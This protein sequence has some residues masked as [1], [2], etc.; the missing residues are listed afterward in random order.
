MTYKKFLHFAVLLL[1]VSIPQ[2]ASANSYN[3]FDVTDGL[4][5]KDDI[6]SGGPQ[7]DGIPALTLPQFHPAA[8]DRFLK[9]NDRILGIV[10]GSTAKA[11][12]LKILNWHE[13]INDQI[14][15]IQFV[16]TYCPLCGTGVAFSSVVNDK[17]LEFGVSGLLY[18]SDVL[19]YDRQTESLWSQILGQAVTGPL[20]GT[21]LELIPV[22]HTSWKRWKETSPKTLVLS[23]K[24]GFHRDYSH[25]PYAGYTNSSDLYFPVTAKSQ[26]NLHPKETV[27][28]ITIGNKHKA[29]P[30]S[31]LA[32]SAQSQISD[33][34]NGEFFTIH[35]D[36][37]GYSAQAYNLA[38]N[39]IQSIQG[40]WF[41]WY[42]FHPD[43]ELYTP[44]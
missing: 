42:A 39:P 9:E 4:I 11:Y 7:K 26:E 15:N 31:T 16:V 34:L 21:E 33:S 36:Q 37:E 27:L 28:G 29:Y 24:T 19:L 32:E 3:G 20:R 41:A 2:Q 14:D 17:A 13:V 44:E 35:W 10:I 22:T 38:G 25:N 18:N 6:L 23:E 40:F 43:T 30:F 1:L 12:P 8:H 5:D